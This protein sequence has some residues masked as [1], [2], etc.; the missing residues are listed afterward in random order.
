MNTEL[1]A[2]FAF[3]LIAALGW[4]GYSHVFSDASGVPV[5]LYE[6]QGRVEVESGGA[7]S[8]AQLGGEIGPS[9]RI[10]AGDDGRAVLG[11]GGENRLTLEANTS[12]QITSVDTTGVRLSL[13][14]GRVRATVRSG[15]PGVAIQAGTRQIT[16]TDADFDITRGEDGV[17]VSTSRGAID[18][19]GVPLGDGQRAILPPQGDPLQ[20]PASDS[21]LLQMSWPG[22]T[23][24]ASPSVL[25]TGQTEP[26]ARVRVQTSSARADTQSDKLG[27]FEVA[28]A[29]GEGANVV[30][31]EA[32]NMFGQ[33]SEAR[34]TVARDSTPPK[35]G[36]E[37]Q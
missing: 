18:V 12:V 25:V 27:N 31:V 26:L 8:M 21:L 19:D 24:T 14:N 9:D 33:T 22:A 34:W 13:E 32:T 23:R 36:V 20:L 1:R 2:L 37:I 11:L 4:V 5:V 29:L 3:L 10:F 30:V 17:G 35:I 16:A 7:R 6:V 28:I 15:G